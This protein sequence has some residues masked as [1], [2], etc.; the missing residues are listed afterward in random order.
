MAKEWEDLTQQEQKK[1]INKIAKLTS[2]KMVNLWNKY[3]FD[4]RGEI[5]IYEMGEFDEYFASM[6]PTQ[7]VTM[8]INDE[9]PSDWEDYKYFAFND[10]MTLEFFDDI[11]EFSSFENMID[12]EGWDGIAAFVVANDIDLDGCEADDDNLIVIK[13]TMEKLYNKVFSILEKQ[14]TEEGK[15]LFDYDD[16]GFIVSQVYEYYD[17]SENDEIIEI[18]QHIW[19]KYVEHL[20]SIYADLEI[21][22]EDAVG[23][24][25]WNDDL[26]DD[27]E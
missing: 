10:E 7:M 17:D 24:K 27:E 23:I 12:E 22:D 20:K 11:E 14:R 16:V 5:L 26:F 4:N 15:K 2:E 21:L 25:G 6:T 9:I 18:V 1:I 8:T 3:H 13:D 19:E